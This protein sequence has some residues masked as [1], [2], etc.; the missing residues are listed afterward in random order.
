MVSNG[1]VGYLKIEEGL[2]RIESDVKTNMAVDITKIQDALS[3]AEV[4]LLVGIPSLFGFGMLISYLISRS[5]SKPLSALKMAVQEISKGNYNTSLPTN[6]ADEI[7]DLAKRFA[8]MVESF[9]N[10]LE[11]ERQLTIAQEKLKTEKLSAVGELAARIAHDLRNPLAVLKNSCALVK[12]QLDGSDPKIQQYIT[13]ME[14]SIDRMSHQIEDVLE[15]VRT[16]P[17]HKEFVAIRELIKKSIDDIDLPKDTLIIMPKNDEK[18]NCDAQKIR[19]VFTNILLNGIQAMEGKGTISIK[20]TGYTKFVNI[21]ITDSGPGMPEEN[22]Q[23][24]FEPLFTTKQTG[25]GL[26][27]ASCKSIVEQHRGAISAKNNPTTFK[28]TLPRL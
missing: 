3:E 23:K 24:I 13:K 18:I 19:T 7:G 11:T 8:S 12:M 14:N 26:G 17:T 9:K 5:V 16:T 20:I 2:A 25:T 21:E 15:F 22:L 10:T 4:L 1:I 6:R 27:L 28:I